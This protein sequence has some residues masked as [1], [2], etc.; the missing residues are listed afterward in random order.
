MMKH[1]IELPY[2]YFRDILFII[3]AVSSRWRNYVSSVWLNLSFVISSVY[4][5]TPSK[6]LLLSIHF[7]RFWKGSWN[8]SCWN[9]RQS[10]IIKTFYANF[11]VLLKLRSDRTIILGF[12]TV[13]FYFMSH[14]LVNVV[15]NNSEKHY[16]Q[17]SA[18]LNNRIQKFVESFSL[19]ALSW[20]IFFVS[21]WLR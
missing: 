18:M 14:I 16:D 6:Q 1:V 8:C 7:V 12:S 17:I 20:M 13:P 9:K 5:I 21:A 4:Q 11:Q 15:L 10:E 19:P 2:F 3:I